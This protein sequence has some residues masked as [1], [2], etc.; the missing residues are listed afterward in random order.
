MMMYGNHKAY[1]Y[2][3]QNMK[4]G[5]EGPFKKYFVQAWAQR[6]EP[7]WSCFITTKFKGQ[8]AK[9][10]RTMRSWVVRRIRIAFADSMK[11][12]GFTKDGEPL[13]GNGTLAP[14]YGTV[15]FIAEEHI[16]KLK[17]AEIGNQMDFC[18]KKMMNKQRPGEEVKPAKGANPRARKISRSSSSIK[19][20]KK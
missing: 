14:I 20:Q 15:Q 16:V 8:E 10:K 4:I 3:S 11:R 19:K 13:E 12:H 17:M 1:T 5:H 9:I 18:V 2:T 6:Q 7:L